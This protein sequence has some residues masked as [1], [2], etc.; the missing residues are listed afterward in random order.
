VVPDSFSWELWHYYTHIGASVVQ[1][2]FMGL[3]ILLFPTRPLTFALTANFCIQLFWTNVLKMYHHSPRPFWVNEQI[4]PDSCYT[5]F[6]NPSGHSIFA[7]FFAMYLYYWMFHYKAPSFSEQARILREQRTTSLQNDEELQIHPNPVP[8][9]K[10][11][12]FAT[13]GTVIRFVSFLILLLGFLA[14]GLSRLIL[15]V[16][17]LNQV[18]YG[19]MLG[20]WTLGFVIQVVQPLCLDMVL[21][22]KER[23]QKYK[24]L[25]VWLLVV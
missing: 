22:V 1:C 18:I 24:S 10:E 21:L 8:A 20:L 5:Q 12:P 4:T 9:F 14:I 3:N 16:H 15:G 25:F 6:G 11:A 23:S 2:L 13:A 19:F 7:A 17:S